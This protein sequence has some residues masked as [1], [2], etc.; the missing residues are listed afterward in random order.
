MSCMVFVV[1][2]DVTMERQRVTLFARMDIAI[3]TSELV[4]TLLSSILMAPSPWLPMCLGLLFASLGSVLLI[5]LPETLGQELITSRAVEGIPDG[6]SPSVDNFTVPYNL[7]KTSLY[8][9]IMGEVKNGIVRIWKSSEVW[10]HNLQILCLLSTFSVRRL[11]R[12]SAKLL[13]PYISKH[14]SLTIAQS[15]ILMSLRSG[16][17]IVLLLLILPCA[18]YLLGMAG[19]T[20]PWKDLLLARTSSILLAVGCLIIGLSLRLDLVIVGLVVTTLGSVFS[21]IVRS[22]LSSMVETQQLG[23]VFAAAAVFDTLGMLTSGPALAGLLHLGLEWGGM[24]RGLPFLGAGAMYSL[25]V[26]IMCVAAVGQRGHERPGLILQEVLP[27]TLYF[28]VRPANL[29]LRDGMTASLSMPSAIIMPSAL[30]CRPPLL[31]RPSEAHGGATALHAD[32]NVLDEPAKKRNCEVIRHADPS[33]QSAFALIY[34]RAFHICFIGGASVSP[35]ALECYCIPL[36]PLVLEC[37]E[38]EHGV[39]NWLSA[40]VMGIQMSI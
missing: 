21:L 14:F 26:C 36:G 38:A 19:L 20:G 11:G 4:A 34:R 18:A 22:L 8:S 1:V 13:L 3:L 29:P 6:G 31:C 24:Y 28:V 25:I 2:A 12:M 7:R 16:V 23:S 32:N 40:S 33:P 35:M 39:G 5:A 27:G 10:L 30:S 37:S 17:S 15:G 9:T